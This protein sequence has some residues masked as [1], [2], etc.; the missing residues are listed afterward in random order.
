MGWQP[1]LDELH[2][3]ALLGGADKVA[4]Q[5]AGGRRKA[6]MPGRECLLHAAVTHSQRG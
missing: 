3:A 4:R 1:E 6:A 2:F 5:H